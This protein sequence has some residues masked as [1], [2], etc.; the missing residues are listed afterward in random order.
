M[1]NI[2]LQ[3]KVLYKVRKTCLEMLIDRGYVIPEIIKTVSY[4]D[5][6]IMFDNKNIDLNII[7]D[8]LEDQEQV[9]SDNE[10]DEEETEPINL[11]KRNIFVFFQMNDTSF[12]KNDFKKI[13]SEVQNRF[14]T[15]DVLI[16]LILKDKPNNAVRKELKNAK[17]INTE[18]FER[19]NLM[20]NVTKHILVPKHIKLTK[21]ETKE[22][23][24]KYSCTKIQLSKILIND[25]QVKYHG[26]KIGDVCKIVRNNKQNGTEISYRIVIAH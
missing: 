6:K 17:Y 5:F 25:P 20:F 24:E 3:E 22:I 1:D 21:E 15:D 7:A 8:E 13:V 4:N 16:I 12:G 19:K 18:I 14:E 10:V 11:E 9:E 23:M 26:M 2:Q